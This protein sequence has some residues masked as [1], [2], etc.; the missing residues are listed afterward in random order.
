M[1][2]PRALR[3]ARYADG[4]FDQPSIPSAIGHVGQH[5][6]RMVTRIHTVIEA[7]DLAG[8]VDQDADAL[9]VAILGT[10]AGAASEPE[11]PLRVA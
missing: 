5:L 7:H 1:G 11:R 4:P 8:F 6:R 9:G 10:R 3:S 2:R